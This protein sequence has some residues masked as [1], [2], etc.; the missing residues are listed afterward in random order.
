MERRPPHVEPRDHAQD[1]VGR[2]SGRAL[3]RRETS[4]AGNYTRAD[5][6]AEDAVLGLARRARVDTRRLPARR[7]RARP[8]AG[9]AGREGHRRGAVGH[10]DRRR[11]QRGGGDRAQAREPPRARLPR[12]PARDRGRLGRVERPDERA[13]R[14]RRR[15]RAARPPARLPARRQGRGAGSRGAR[16]DERGRRVLGRERDLGARRAP[17]ARREPRR[18]RRRLRLR[19]AA[20]RGRG[21]IEPRGPLLALRALAARA[22]VAP[23]LDHGR[24]RLDLRPPP[25]R[26]RRGRPAL[27][28]RPR[29][30]L[31]DGAGRPPRGLRARGARVREA[32]TDE[33]GGVRPQG[34]DVRALL[35]DH[36][37]RLDAAA[38]AARLPRLGR[39]APPAALRQ[40]GAPPRPARDKHRA[41]ADRAGRTP[42]RSSGSSPCSRRSRRASRSRG[43]TCYVTWATVQALWNYLRRGVPATWEA[44]EGTR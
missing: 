32:D 42:S 29:V 39:L 7:R 25:R 14:G 22:G 36:A 31:P 37:A 27:G 35:G 10:R 17:P 34:A 38:A 15:A 43:T 11:V 8:R 41:R 9:T 26:L 13:R 5:A 21:G 1:T 19:A 6:R 28:A 12:R 20:A 4:D 44:A 23:R 30:S 3:M 2:P 24:Q 33:R 18:S 16:D 40:R